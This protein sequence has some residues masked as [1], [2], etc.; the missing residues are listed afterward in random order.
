MLDDPIFGVISVK[1]GAG[2]KAIRL[3]PKRLLQ[4]YQKLLQRTPMLQ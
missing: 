1:V 4:K 3:L 2:G